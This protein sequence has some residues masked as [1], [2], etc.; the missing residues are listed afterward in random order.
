MKNSIFKRTGI[1]IIIA[2]LAL[3]YFSCDDSGVVAPKT[4]TQFC[5]TAKLSGWVPGNKTLYAQVNSNSSGFFRVA[6]CPV[7][8]A[9]NF[10][11]CLPDLLDTTLFPA[12]SIFY[13]GC[14]GGTVSFIPPDAIGTQIFNFRVVQDSVVCGAVDCNNFSRYDSIKA[15]DFEMMFIYVNKLVTASGYKLCD[16]DTLAF[17]GTAQ[18]GWNKIFKH[19]TRVDPNSRTILYDMV[20]PPGAV[21]EYHGN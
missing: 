3:I 1:L 12:D 5:I 17:S 13:S 11:L 2:I 21:W 6:N 20:E 16:N 15:G 7:D 14:N 4:D 19:Y 18:K 8:S 10:N 9:G